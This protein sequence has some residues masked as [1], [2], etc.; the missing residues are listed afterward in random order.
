VE[1][2]F[3]T[4]LNIDEVDASAISTTIR[5]AILGRGVV[6]I[7]VE[8][9]LTPGSTV[10]NTKTTLASEADGATTK[11]YFDELAASGTAGLDAALGLPITEVGAVSEVSA[12][13]LSLPPPPLPPL[14]PP[15]ADGGSNLRLLLL[16]LL[17]LFLMPVFF[18]IYAWCAFGPKAGDYFKYSFSHSNPYIIF[19]YIPAERRKELGDSLFRRNSSS[20]TSED[21]PKGDAGAPGP[22]TS[23][24]TTSEKGDMPAED[25]EKGDLETKSDGEAKEGAG[26]PGPSCAPAAVERI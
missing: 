13:S 11:A 18:Y 15:P 24:P 23:S 2:T 22:S 4:S 1:F 6:P 12:A 25:M 7:A 14:S 5:N 10:V 3:T 17:L 8:I 21:K 19:F 20:D 16:L 9:T 26:A